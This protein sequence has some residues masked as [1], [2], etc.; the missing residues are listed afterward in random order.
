[1]RVALFNYFNG[2]CSNC[3]CIKLMK[4]ASGKCY[5]KLLLL[6]RCLDKCEVAGIWSPVGVKYWKTSIGLTRRQDRNVSCRSVFTLYGKSHFYYCTS[7]QSAVKKFIGT[8][9]LQIIYLMCVRNKIYYFQHQLVLQFLLRYLHLRLGIT[10]DL[11]A[12]IKKNDYLFI[13]V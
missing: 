5:N 7:R 9:N 6:W 2:S 8:I 1:M 3:I 10:S 4:C 12:N 13:V 11:Q